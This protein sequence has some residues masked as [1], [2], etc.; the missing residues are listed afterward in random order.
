MG[1]GWREGEDAVTNGPTPL[2]TQS[3]RTSS[4][5]QKPALPYSDITVTS[6]GRRG[7]M[8]TWEEKQK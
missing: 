5:A 4:S 8:E 7:K 6:V 1:R 2:A 3:D